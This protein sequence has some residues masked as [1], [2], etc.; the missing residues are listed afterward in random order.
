M[1]TEHISV[2]C[3]SA[4]VTSVFSKETLVAYIGFV[5]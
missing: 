4:W 3:Y 1:P 2:V 5:A